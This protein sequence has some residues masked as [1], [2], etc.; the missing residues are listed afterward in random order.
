MRVEVAA[1]G[2]LTG[3][4]APRPDPDAAQPQLVLQRD[5]MGMGV[6][7]T[8]DLWDLAEMAPGLFVSSE[9]WPFPAACSG[10]RPAK[11]RAGCGVLA[12][13]SGSA[14]P[15]CPTGSS[16]PSP[17]LPQRSHQARKGAPARV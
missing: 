2:P 6:S 8:G 12:M 17:W 3:W 10:L 5:S 16:G 15:M 4:W 9:P 7:A 11:I 1:Q 14:G 13:D